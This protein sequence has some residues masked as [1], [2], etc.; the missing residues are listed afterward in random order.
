MKVSQRILL[1][2]GLIGL[3][4]F[5]VA[6]DTAATKPAGKAPAA[7]L[8]KA[9]AADKGWLAK[10]GADYPLDTCVVSGD[11]LGDMGKPLEYIFK[12]AGQP[13]RL[14]RFCCGDCPPKF[15]KEPAKYL[16][17]IDDA[18]AAKAKAKSAPAA[19]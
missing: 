2:A 18:A 6:A 15:E 4:S 11:K 17:I 13:D 16:K 10:A 9:D 1:L 7:V 19:K 5:S 3:A 14:V 12:Q 8:V